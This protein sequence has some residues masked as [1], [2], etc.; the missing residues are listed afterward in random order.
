MHAWCIW[1]RSSLAC[2][3]EPMCCLQVLMHIPS[4]ADM[5]SPASSSAQPGKSMGP[6][7]FGPHHEHKGVCL[8]PDSSTRV[9]HDRAVPASRISVSAGLSAGCSACCAA[10]C[11]TQGRIQ[12]LGLRFSGLRSYTGVAGASRAS[13]VWQCSSA[14]GGSTSRR[15]QHPRAALKSQL[16]QASV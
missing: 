9:A 2:L 5:H 6:W 11:A 12:D 13:S 3:A 8:G 16:G 7:V 1:G 4:L 10:S 15:C 14:H